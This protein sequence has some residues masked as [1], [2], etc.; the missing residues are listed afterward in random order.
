MSS[1]VRTGTVSAEPVTRGAMKNYLKLP[2][3]NQTD[4]TLIDSLI[5]AARVQAEI[6][7]ECALVRSTF[8]QYMNRF[9]GRHDHELGSFQHGRH[10]VENHH[11]H[12]G[13]IKMKRGPLVSVQSLIY[14]GTDGNPYPLSPGEDFIVDPATQPGRIRPVPYTV[15]PLTLCVPNA[16]AIAFTAGYAPG[17]VG[18]SIDAGQTPI[19]EPETS[20]PAFGPNWRPGALRPQFGFLI[21][22]SGNVEVQMSAGSPA[23]GATEPTWPA[24]GAT[25]PDGAALYKNFGPLRGVWT[26]DT[27]YSGNWV[28]LDKNGNLQLL[29][30]PSLISQT[31]PPAISDGAAGPPF[32]STLGAITTDNG[33]PAWQCLGAYKAL[34]NS[35]AS[36]SNTPEQQAA[37]TVDLALP[38][39]IPIALMQLVAH[40]YFN[41]EPVIAG[42]AFEVPLHVQNLL[43]TVSVPDYAPTPD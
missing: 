7:T 34:G 32:S 14:I 39:T 2:P 37:Y 33:I 25:V 23:A 19:A 15:W 24:P 20:T 17:N 29:I 35:G 22:P 42:G 5:S 18:V 41:R 9:P 8:V 43:A 30:V 21:D 11:H 10:S 16:V 26:P 27:Q 38:P 31:S 40:W 36:T 28:I 3:S 12:H 4:D 6:I 13:E 1:I